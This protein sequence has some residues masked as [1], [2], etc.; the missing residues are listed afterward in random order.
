MRYKSVIAVIP[1]LVFAAACS[2]SAVEASVAD[3]QAMLLAAMRY[4][5]SRFVSEQYDFVTF[6]MREGAVPID[7]SHTE[8][9]AAADW[10]YER[11]GATELPVRHFNNCRVHVGGVF[12]PD[13]DGLGIAIWCG[14][15]TLTSADSAVLYAGYFSGGLASQGDLLRLHRENRTWRVVSHRCV[16]LS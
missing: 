8:H 3:E 10:V 13:F 1:F 2:D 7:R 15:I 6:A 11:I 14:S 5:T 12:H 4:E 16:W 9:T